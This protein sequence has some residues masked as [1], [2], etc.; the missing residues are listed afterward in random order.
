MAT[1]GRENTLVGAFVLG[2]FVLLFWGSLQIGAFSSFFAPEGRVFLARFDNVAGL[3]V[4]TDVLM[5]GV[6]IGKVTRI[7]LVGHQARV[8][9]RITD[10]ALRI[11]VDSVV[12]IR[13]HG[14][15]GERVLEIV[16]GQST[17]GLDPGGVFT[18]TRAAAD[19]DVLIDRISGV[20]GDIQQVSATLRNVL[21][22]PEG[23]EA[24]QEVLANT[25][26]MSSH[27]RSIVENNEEGIERIVM[28]LD[29]FSSD[30][31]ELSDEHKEDVR[32][33]L[34]GLRDASAKVNHALDNLV[35]V[36]DR[37]ERGEGT[38]GMLMS[39]DGLYQEVDAAIADVRAA[40]RE[41][42][43]A[44]EETQEQIPATVLTTLFGSLF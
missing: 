11:P 38:L 42:R 32:V 4:E 6:A 33:L 21:G 8:T 7:E 1:R 31:A 12:T 24:L 35:E 43:R 20:A 18:R 13:S 19:V 39:D 41:V 26:A 34:G 37:I 2:T 25:R 36:S 15:L 29:A 10:P 22:G 14:L 16:P 23:E 40:L 28:N 44:A 27:L 5:A 3:D 30:L 17:R 9:L